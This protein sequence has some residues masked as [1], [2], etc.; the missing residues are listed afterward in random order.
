M[1]FVLFYNLKYTPAVFYPVSAF[2]RS[3]LLF[4]IQYFQHVVVGCTVSSM[5]VL[6]CWPPGQSEAFS[7]VSLKQSISSNVFCLFCPVAMVATPK[8]SKTNISHTDTVIFWV[9]SDLYTSVR[10]AVSNSTFWCRSQ[11]VSSKETNKVC[12]ESRFKWIK[13]VDVTSKN[14]DEKFQ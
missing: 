9:S 12:L 13:E 4:D 10:T 1:A 3:F 14:Y 6:S 8:N 7:S 5:F 11:F 2:F